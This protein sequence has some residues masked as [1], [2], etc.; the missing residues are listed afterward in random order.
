MDTAHFAETMSHNRQAIVDT[1]YRMA[2]QNEQ[3]AL[4]A[5]E[6]NR[7]LRAQTKRTAEQLIARATEQI[8]RFAEQQKALFA[9][10]E[11]QYRK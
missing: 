2:D 10:A 4:E 5:I 3:L 8:T 6:I 1:C 11:F 7:Q 9:S